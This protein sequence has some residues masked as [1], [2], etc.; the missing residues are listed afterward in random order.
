MSTTT[1]LLPFEGIENF[2]DFGDYAA[3]VRRLKRGLLFRS[4]HHAEATDADL[5]KL[6][7]LGLSVIVDLRRSNERA[8]LPSKR[9]PG[10]GAEVIDNDIG[11]EHADEWHEFIA[12]S[13]LTAASFRQYMLDYY[14]GAPHAKRHVDLYARYFR[15]L[16]QTEG[17]VLV[18][19]AAG[20]DRTGI[21]CALTHHV[22]GVHEDDI[23]AD[24]LL[25]NDEERIARRLPTIRARIAEAS[26]RQPDDAALFVAMRVEAE[27]LERAFA[28]M[29]AQHG[30]IDGY[31]DA[32][33]GLTPQLRERIHDRLL[34]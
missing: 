21:L 28:A 22:A 26:G 16:A 9:W 32:A 6:A 20:K 27:Y 11:Q 12:G 3:G 30:S 29:R 15:A 2:R 34:G 7:A 4:A 13:D 8:S 23:I 5:A 33:L 31:L 19:C 14:D 24:Y 18:H 17:A 1:R 10:F 25:T